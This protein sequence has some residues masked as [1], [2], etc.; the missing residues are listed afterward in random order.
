MSG[1]VRE[2]AAGTAERLRAVLESVDEGALTAETDQAAFLR[3]AVAALEL[4]ADGLRGGVSDPS[5]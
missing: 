2:L 5:L 1:D 4:V 3:G